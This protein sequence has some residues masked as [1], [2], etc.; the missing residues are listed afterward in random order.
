MKID[1]VE[2]QRQKMCDAKIDDLSIQQFDSAHSRIKEVDTFEFHAR[3]D[4]HEKH[5]GRQL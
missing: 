1:R 5:T 4:A 3:A 2:N